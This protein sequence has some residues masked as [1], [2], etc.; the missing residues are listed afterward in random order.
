MMPGEEVIP[1][2]LAVGVASYTMR[3]GGYLAAAW[4]PQGGWLPRVLRLAPG[5]LF[6]AFTG[7]A[8]HQ[9]GWPALC[10]CL[11]SLVAMM[12]TRREWA[13]LGAGFAS[14]AACAA[15]VR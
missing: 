13:A 12:L 15:W 4:L 14:A 5:N 3:A 9:G 7:A 10:G 6:I 8:I 1:A 11:A 2:I